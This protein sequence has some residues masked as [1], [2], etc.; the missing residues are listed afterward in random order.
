MRTMIEEGIGER[1]REETWQVLRERGYV[2]KL[3]AGGGSIAELADEVHA[4]QRAYAPPVPTEHEALP[5]LTEDWTADAPYTLREDVVSRVVSD[6]AAQ[7]HDIQAFRADPRHELDDHLCI[8]ADARHESGMQRWINKM[9]LHDSEEGRK[10]ATC[11]MTELPLPDDYSERVIRLMMEREHAVAAVPDLDLHITPAD[12][13]DHITRGQVEPQPFRY[14]LPGDLGERWTFVHQG[15]IL[16]RLRLLSRSTKARYGW[17]EAQAVAFILTG[18]AP[19]IPSVMVRYNDAPVPAT[20]RI[21][22]T[23]DPTLSPREVTDKYRKARQYLV[24]EYHR[25]VSE[26]HLQLALFAATQLRGESLATRMAAWNQRFPQWAYSRE[27]N[28]GWDS[29]QAKRRVVGL[30][31]GERRKPPAKAQ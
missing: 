31:K 1:L 29:S 24:G 9:S 18:L 15:G 5:M 14:T 13:L 4:G 7:D 30:G 16:D 25:E 12:L 10:H 6:L 3:L 22:L 27:S 19:L 17:A 23:V 28:F 20:S 21:V 2:H 26:K 8:W 11:F